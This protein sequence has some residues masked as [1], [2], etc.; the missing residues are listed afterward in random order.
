MECV[1]KCPEYAP[2]P[3]ASHVCEP[4]PPDA[5]YFDDVK[6]SSCAEVYADT[7]PFWDPTAR[8]CVRKCPRGLEPA[9]SAENAKTCRTCAEISPEKPDWDRDA[10]K[11]VKCPRTTQNGIC[12]PCYEMDSETPFWNEDAKGCLSCA[13]AFPNK[14]ETWNPNARACVEKCPKATPVD[15]TTGECKICE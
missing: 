3:N 2:V 4:C 1:S 7:R 14:R 13:D 15:K 11:C 9:E 10:E 5:P 6:C 8:A 12:T